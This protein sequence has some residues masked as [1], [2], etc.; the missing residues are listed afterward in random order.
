MRRIKLTKA[1][2]ILRLEALD[3]YFEQIFPCTGWPARPTSLLLLL[4]LLV[5][6]MYKSVAPISILLKF[7]HVTVEGL[8]VDLGLN[9]SHIKS[10]PAVLTA[11]LLEESHT[12]NCNKGQPRPHQGTFA[13]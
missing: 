6:L 4:V 2:L 12:L 9:G 11:H 3:R 13:A 8:L 1:L 10:L 7:R 5:V